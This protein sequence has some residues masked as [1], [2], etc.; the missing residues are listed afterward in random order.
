MGKKSKKPHSKNNKQNQQIIQM[1]GQYSGPLPIPSHL[2]QYEQ[3]LPGAADRIIRMAEKQSEHRQELE[4]RVIKSD[5]RNSLA[6]LIFGFIIGIVG[7]VRG[8]YLI[9]IGQIIEGSIFGGGTIVSLVGTFIYG[10]QKRQK[11][12]QSRQY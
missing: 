12:R 7:I 4:K 11:E 6:G 1:S 5:T 8:A 3:I 10:S 9:S 2:E